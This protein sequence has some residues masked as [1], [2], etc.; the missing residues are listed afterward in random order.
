M[1]PGDLATFRSIPEIGMLK[2]KYVGQEMS[3]GPYAKMQYV[4]AVT[5]RTNR[6][7][8]TGDLIKVFSLTHI[9]PRKG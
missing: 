6:Y 5:S 8:K 1:K 2:V 7:H 4:F 3:P 9:Y